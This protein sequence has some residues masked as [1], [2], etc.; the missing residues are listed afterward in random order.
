MR[1][2]AP[3]KGPDRDFRPDTGSLATK[4]GPSESRTEDEGIAKDREGIAN[5]GNCRRMTRLISVVGKV[6]FRTE[7]VRLRLTFRL[8]A[9]RPDSKAR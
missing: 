3:S 7:Q 6:R 5:V 1:P 4:A 2:L 8:V 9:A